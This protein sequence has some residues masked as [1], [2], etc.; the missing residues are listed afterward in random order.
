[1]NDHDHPPQPFGPEAEHVLRLA[2]GELGL[3]SGRAVG[4][5]TALRRAVTHPHSTVITVDVSELA[6]CDSS[7]LNILLRARLT[8]LTHGH[9]LH[10]KAPTPQLLRLL[11]RTGT[12]TLFILDTPPPA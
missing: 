3:D 2:R 5:D 1:M 9:T 8:A 12:S 10:L 11:D 6:F 4:I 7:G